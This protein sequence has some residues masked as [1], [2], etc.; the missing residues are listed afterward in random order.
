MGNKFDRSTLA[1]NTTVDGSFVRCG[2]D[3]AYEGITTTK[4]DEI[5]LGKKG[6]DAIINR[7]KSNDI[8]YGD[9][10]DDALGVY[11][12]GNADGYIWLFGG[13]GEDYLWSD[14]QA[15]GNTWM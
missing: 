6:I 5:I 1:C 12:D 15:P 13:E 4:N 8:Y 2:T 3:K 7:D 11:N 10:G 14:G 9:E